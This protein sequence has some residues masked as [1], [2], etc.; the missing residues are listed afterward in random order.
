MALDSDPV[1]HARPFHLPDSAHLPQRASSRPATAVGSAA[2]R[3]KPRRLTVALLVRVL[4]AD[5]DA[6]Y[7]RRD[8]RFGSDDPLAM[9]VG[10][11][12]PKPHDAAAQAGSPV[13]A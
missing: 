3:R 10:A 4:L 9:L 2:A 6:R 7:P 12:E 11:G 13:E 5:M 1:R 8:L